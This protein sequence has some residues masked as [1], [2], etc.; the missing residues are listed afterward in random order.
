MDLAERLY[1]GGRIGL[2]FKVAGLWLTVTKG[3]DLR[4]WD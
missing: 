3:F 4:G 1:K 2:C